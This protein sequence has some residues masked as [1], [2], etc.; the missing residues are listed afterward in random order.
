MLDEQITLL[1]LEENRDADGYNTPT[2]TESVIYAEV[3]S[4]FRNEFYEAMKAG[5]KLEA[6]FKVVSDDYNNQEQVKYNGK[7]LDI[8]RSHPIDRIYTRLVC[9]EV[10]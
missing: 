10:T 8:V 2:V 3:Q 4:P 6:T 7:T 1:N 9:K 5:V